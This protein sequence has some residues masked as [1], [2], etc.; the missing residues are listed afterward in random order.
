MTFETAAPRR[1][2]RAGS[3]RASG[4]ART[5]WPSTSSTSPTGATPRRPPAGPRARAALL[6]QVSA[7]LAGAAGHRVGAR[8]AGAAG[9]P[10]AHRR[11]HRH[12]GR[13]GGPRPGRRLLARRPGAARADGSGTP[14]VRLDS[15]PSASPVAR[16]LHAGHAGD[17]VGRRRP[18]TSCRPARPA[19]CCRPRPGD[20]GGAAA[21]RG[22]P[23]GRR[24]HPV[25]GRR[26]GSLSEEDLETARQVA[27]EAGRAV[28]RVHRQSQQAQ[29]AEALQR[30]LLTDPPAIGGAAG[31]RPVRAGRGGRPRGRRL[32]RRLPAARR[33]AGRRH[34]RRRR[35]RHRGRGGHGPAARRCC[36]ASPTTA[37]PGRPRCCAAWT[38]PSRT[39]T[40]T[41]WP[42]PRSPGSSAS[43]R[44]R[45]LRPAALGQRR[46]PAADRGRARRGGRRCSAARS[47]T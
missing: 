21:H 10:R 16:A 30:S 44:R 26:A 17:R 41:P 39:C 46:P 45:R 27:A 13:P 14:Q 25:P 43:R 42:R 24:P 6:A 40:P 3:R 37:G 20:G 8:P 15:L 11:L 23:H 9:R 35:A 19:T 32:V 12:R 36:A 31:R 7:E 2:G 1:A 22:G 5:A 34:R 28:A 47:A 38:R 4:R 33:R 18:R 29:L